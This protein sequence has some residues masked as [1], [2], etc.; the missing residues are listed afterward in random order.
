MIRKVFLLVTFLFINCISNLVVANI[1]QKI[2]EAE[3]EYISNRFLNAAFMFAD[4]YKSLLTAA[5]G[6]FA[7]NGEQLKANEVMPIASATKPFT[8]AG[9]LRLQ[10][11]KLLN[12]NDKIYKYI[13]AEMWQG[14]VPD[15][16]HKIS[17]HNL[18]THSSG[19]AEYFSFVKLDLNM[20]KKEA[21][22]KILGFVASKPLEISI[23]KKFKHS[24]TNFVILGM[25]IE[26]VSKKDLSNFFQDEFFK[27]LNM[28][29]TSFASYSEAARIQR[30]VV[31]SNYPVRYFI[32]PN[33]SN[34]PIF[35]PVTSNFVAVPCADGRII[36]TPCD[37]IK[38]Y[39]AL[40][41][42]KILSK[43]SYKLMTTK[44]FFAKE[45]DNRKTYMGYG[46]YLTELDSKHLMIHYTGRALGVQSEVG[47]ILPNNLYFAILSNTMVKI[48][49]EEKDKID[50]SN[51]LN[52]LGIVYFRDAIINAAIKDDVV[53][54]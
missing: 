10:E 5:K 27:P 16:A 6:I 47:Y 53:V 29:S 48:P 30:N 14:K 33:N 11:Q 54:N 21:R 45:I 20:S 31:S 52:Q 12:V 19:I 42:G 36:S 38:W 35:T 41:Q 28:K 9:I 34:K 44:Y 1:Q 8:A 43:K 17:I 15:W 49:K 37:L 7:L 39:R 18:L 24:N 13:D 4:D 40:N 2:I 51:P 3:K 32:T 22:K 25:I 50:M 26:K 46:I 23:G